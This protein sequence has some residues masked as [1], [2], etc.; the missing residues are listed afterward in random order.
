[1]QVIEIEQTP[2]RITRG[3]YLAN[4][5]TL[6]MDCHSTRDWS[7]YSGPMLQTDL[8][9]GGELFSEDMG[10]PGKFYAANITTHKLGD[11]TDG[12][13]LRA[14]TT[15]VNRD[16]KA[17]FPIMGYPRFGRMDQEDIYSIIA[18]IR[19]LEPV[20][21]EIPGSEPAFPVNFL[22]NT[23]PKPAAFSQKP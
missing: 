7:R 6:C 17:L 9:G 10:F 23:M 16:G 19:T 21:H 15:G 8:G 11:W 18:Y 14:V 3:R 4:H 5:V 22:I 1:P 2:D 12:E 20:N 13:I